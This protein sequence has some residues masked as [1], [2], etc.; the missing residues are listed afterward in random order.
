MASGTVKWFNDASDYGL[1]VR[2]DNAT[3]LYV[4]GSSI[5]GEAGARLTAGDRVEFEERVAGMG[6]EAIA[7]R[8]VN[9]RA[10]LRCACGYGIVADGVL[11]ACPMCGE[12]AWEASTEAAL[13]V[14]G[15]RG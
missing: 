2:D 5:E 12:N 4:R 14:G 9:L 7:V 11:P 6:H 8:P 3:D 15:R 10:D 1:I 13:A